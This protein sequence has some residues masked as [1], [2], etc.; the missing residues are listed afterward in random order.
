M[1]NILRCIYLPMRWSRL[2]IPTLREVPAHPGTI[3]H[4]L[5]LRAG[6]IRQISPAN[7]ARL[8]LAERAL[9]KLLRIIRRE[10]EGIGGQEIRLPIVHPADRKLDLPSDLEAVANLSKS[11]LRSYSKRLVNPTVQEGKDCADWGG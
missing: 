9:Q 10:M 4:Q 3:S 6:Y 11:E 2:F 5:L 1:S 7:Y 8:T